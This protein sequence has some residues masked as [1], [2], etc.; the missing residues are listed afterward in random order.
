MANCLNCDIHAKIICCCGE[1]P[2]TREKVKLKIGEEIFDACPYLNKEGLCSIHN[3]R[4]EICRD[5]NEC[6]I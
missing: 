2:E 3:S 5:F 4:P 1:H 6:S